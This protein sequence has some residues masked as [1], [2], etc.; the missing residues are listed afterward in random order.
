MI[1]IQSVQDE[2]EANSVCR[3]GILAVNSRRYGRFRS[4]PGSI[5]FADQA[6]IRG[7]M[8]LVQQEGEENPV[9][10]ANA[11]ARGVSTIE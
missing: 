8:A 10:H 11:E 4:T 2:S 7:F 5:A 9:A 3:A 1:F 6:G